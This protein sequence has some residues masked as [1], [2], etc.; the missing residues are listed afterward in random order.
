[1]E[2]WN[3][4]N[5]GELNKIGR[6]YKLYWGEIYS[7][8]YGFSIRV[9]CDDL[10]FIDH[11]SN[12]YSLTNKGTGFQGLKS[13][14]LAFITEPALEEQKYLE[15]YDLIGLLS[16]GEDFIVVLGLK[17]YGWFKSYLLGAFGYFDEIFNSSVSLHAGLV[18][19]GG[20]GILI[21]APSGKGKSAIS[22]GLKSQPAYSFISDD[23]VKVISPEGLRGDS[24]LRMVESDLGYYPNGKNILFRRH[25]TDNKI[26]VSLKDI[27]GLPTANSALIEHVV[28][29]DTGSV[30]VDSVIARIMQASPQTPFND[31]CINNYTS[32]WDW[33][34]EIQSNRWEC[35]MEMLN[36]AQ[37]LVH[38]PFAYDLNESI[39]HILRKLKI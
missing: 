17:H 36:S 9:Y 8:L 24:S 5:Q 4:A 1:M 19:L 38:N 16:E 31:I 3:V 13:P 6:S 11:L 20:S 30:E 26:E 35:L 15:K 22:L 12:E 29:L 37:L 23:W 34:R 39:D 33:V 25:A 14:S 28:I 27:E 32:E 10:S 21:V 18:S 2:Y 7:P